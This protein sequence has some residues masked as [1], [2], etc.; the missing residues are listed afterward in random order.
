VVLFRAVEPFGIYGVSSKPLWVSGRRAPQSA[1]SESS[2]SEQ[3]N[4]QGGYDT[5]RAARLQ[6]E[7]MYVTS[8]SWKT[9]GQRYHGFV[10]DVLFLGFGIEDAA[11]G[12]IDIR[13]GDLVDGIELCV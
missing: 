10:D 4:G 6:S 2:S 1:S 12:L 3:Q 11:T 8:I 5:I 13:A 9:H 7:M